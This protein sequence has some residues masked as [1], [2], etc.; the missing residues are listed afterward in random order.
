MSETKEIITFKDFMKLD[1]KIGKIINVEKVPNSN[2]LFKMQFD[3]G[4]FQRQIVAGIATKYTEEDL[5]SKQIP[6]IVN[7][8]PRLI[9][10]LN[11]QGMILAVGEIDVDALLFPSQDVKNGSPVH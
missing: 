5:L 11:S 10:G 3:F 7:L 4:D 1:I 9:M 2:K 6:V 8:E